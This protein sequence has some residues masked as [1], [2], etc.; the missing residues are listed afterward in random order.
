MS[1]GVGRVKQEAQRAKDTLSEDFTDF[2]E[3]VIPFDANLWPITF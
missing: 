3:M 1:G 2:T